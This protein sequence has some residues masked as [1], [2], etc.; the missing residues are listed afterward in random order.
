MKKLLTMRETCEL[1]RISYSTLHRWLNARAVPMPV[2]GRGRGKRMLWSE[3]SLLAW[4]N[5]HSEQP[6]PAPPSVSS[7]THRNRETKSFQERQR[8][9]AETLQRHRLARSK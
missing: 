8:L 6:A 7:Q 3:E 1:L 9:A 4:V 2:N 5:R